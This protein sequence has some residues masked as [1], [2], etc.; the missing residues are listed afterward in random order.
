MTT[1]H[2]LRQL[3]AVLALPTLLVGTALTGAAGAAGPTPGT[4]FLQTVPALGGVHLVVASIPVTTRSD[5]SVTVHVSDINGAASRVSLGSSVINSR[6]TVALASVHPGR[7]VAKY[8]SHLTVGLDVSSLITLRVDPGHTGV[9]ASDVGVVRLH[10]LTGQ[11]VLVDVRHHPTVRLLARK[12]RVVSGQVTSQVVTWSVDSVRAGKGVSVTT[13][14]GR[15]DPFSDP[16]WGLVL[17]PVAGTVVVDTVPATPGV[18]FLLD[19]ASFS[20]DAHGQG[21]TSVADLNGVDARIALGT[22][23]AASSD[24]VS[25]LRVSRLKPAAAYQR[26]LLV[27]LAVSRPVTLSF[28][29]P[30]GRPVSST[31]VSTVLLDGGGATVTVASSE[32]GDPVT[33]LATQARLV[34][35]KWQALPVTYSV[36]GVMLEGADAVFAGQQRFQPAQGATWPISLS[37]FNVTVTVRDVLFG[38]RISSKA[39]VTRPDGVRY[40]VELAGGR[41]T[42]LTGLVRGQYT[43][44]TKS[45]VIGADAAILVSKDSEVDLRVVTRPDAIVLTVVGLGLATGVL[46]LGRRLRR[47]PARA[48]KRRA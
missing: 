5:G 14:S 29:D 1:R 21:V 32:L 6:T 17:R 25:V 26:H 4:I 34:E 8:Q 15:F 45:A 28:R 44:D 23:H 47:T 37:V 24:S 22:S 2:R 42:M 10:S 30:A 27:A 48:R 33:L 20:T 31:R 40:P 35:G 36:T 3:A 9:P 11:T 18:S 41:A 13:K 43:L 38:S 19:G 46:L 12:S 16:V 39:L 7:H